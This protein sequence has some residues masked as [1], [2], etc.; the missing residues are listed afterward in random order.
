MW[1]KSLTSVVLLSALNIATFWGLLYFYFKSNQL[2]EHIATNAVMISHVG[3]Y[4]N[5]KD[6]KNAKIH[7]DNSIRF[8]LSLMLRYNV[9]VEY[10]HQFRLHVDEFHPDLQPVDIN[11]ISE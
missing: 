11:N 8:N 3:N 9:N 6:I 7:S 5:N 1:R 10:W 4:L 2:E